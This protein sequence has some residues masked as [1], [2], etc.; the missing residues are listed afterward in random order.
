MKIEFAQDTTEDTFEGVLRALV[1]WTVEI[2]KNDQTFVR[3]DIS[4]SF[5]GQR[6]GELDL[7]GIG[8]EGKGHATVMIADI[9]TVEIL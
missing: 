8:R 9:D 7:H 6:D 4:P 3:G 1:G 2:T 5:P